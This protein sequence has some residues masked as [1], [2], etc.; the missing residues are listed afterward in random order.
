[1][2]ETK[3]CCTVHAD[4]HSPRNTQV[5]EDRVAVRQ[6]AT[7]PTMDEQCF[8]INDSAARQAVLPQ[9]PR[10]RD[11]LWMISGCTV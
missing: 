11:L 2:N 7:Y 10:A 8:P 9:E 3:L 1:M 6:A 5:A 4:W